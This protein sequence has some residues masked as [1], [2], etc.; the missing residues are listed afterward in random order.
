MDLS[1]CDVS[2]Q[3]KDACIITIQKAAEQSNNIQLHKGNNSRREEKELI[4]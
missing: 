2:G 3:G 1:L 4:S